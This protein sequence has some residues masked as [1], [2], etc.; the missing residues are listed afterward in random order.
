MMAQEAAPKEF[1]N[2]RHRRL[3]APGKSFTFA[4]VKI[5]DTARPYKAQSK[6]GALGDGARP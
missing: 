3:L 5:G 4:D 1:A 6:K 2:S